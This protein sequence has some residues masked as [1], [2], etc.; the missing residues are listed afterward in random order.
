MIVKLLISEVLEVIQLFGCEYGLVFSCLE[1]FFEEATISIDVRS[2][3][4]QDHWTSLKRYSWALLPIHLHV[5]GVTPLSTS[6]AISYCTEVLFLL[7]DFETDNAYTYLGVIYLLFL[8]Q[9]LVLLKSVTNIRP[10]SGWFYFYRDKSHWI[11]WIAWFYVQSMV[12]LWRS[13]FYEKETGTFD[14]Y[15]M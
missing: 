3:D 11:D 8:H 15:N 14:K 12:I 1:A 13:F 6:K 2:N 5:W 7:N 9:W 10:G 4:F